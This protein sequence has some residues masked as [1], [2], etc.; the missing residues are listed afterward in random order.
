[1]V[2]IE[3]E[4]MS[5]VVDERSSSLDRHGGHRDMKDRWIGVAWYF[6]WRVFFSFSW[7]ASLY[8]YILLMS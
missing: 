3:E 8:P 4:I 2:E 5:G 7:E 1:M 6:G